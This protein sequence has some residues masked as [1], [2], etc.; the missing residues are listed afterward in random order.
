MAAFSLRRSLLVRLFLLTLA[1]PLLAQQRGIPAS[2]Q[3]G[4]VSVDLSQGRAYLGSLAKPEALEQMRD[5]ALLG[6]YTLSAP[7]GASHRDAL[8]SF[9]PVRFEELASIYFRRAGQTRGVTVSD[10]RFIAMVSEDSKGAQRQLQIGR[11]LDEEASAKGRIPSVVLTFEYRIDDSART[12]AIHA[13][14]QQDGATFFTEAAGYVERRVA[15]G[16]DLEAF[17]KLNADIT[18]ARVEQG[19]FIVGGRRFMNGMPQL[20]SREDLAAIRQAGMRISD[21]VRSHLAR[22]GLQVEYEAEIRK[23]AAEALAKRELTGGVATFA[24]IQRI[25]EQL[26]GARPYERFAAEQLNE[27]M[28]ENPPSIGFSLDPRENRPGIAADLEKAVRGDPALFDGWL[29]HQVTEDVHQAR[30][31]DPDRESSDLS[32]IKA[33]L[34]GAERD[35]TRAEVSVRTLIGLDPAPARTDQPYVDKRDEK[36]SDIAAAQRITKGQRAVADR[37]ADELRRV[38]A[39]L[40][41]NS[42]EA[43]RELLRYLNA[44]AIGLDMRPGASGYRVRDLQQLLRESVDEDLVADGQYGAA[45]TSALRRFQE[46]ADLKPTGIVDTTTWKALLENSEKTAGELAELRELLNSVQDH[47]NYQCARY[48]GRLAGTQVGMTLF[49]TD[50]LMKVWS[51]AGPDHQPSVPGFVSETQYRLSPV[52]WENEK[53]FNST[54]GWLGPRMEAIK[55]R[56]EKVSFAPVATRLYNASSNDLINGK[57]V[58]ATFGPQ[59]FSDWWNAHY[60]DVADYEPQYHRLNQIMKWAVVLLKFEDAAVPALRELAD[61]TV[62]RNLRFDTWWATNK[63]HLRVAPINAFRPVASEPTE[64]MDILHSDLYESMG[65]VYVFSGGVS[66]PRREAI[67]AKALANESRT[68][69]PEILKAPGVDVSGARV[70]NSGIQFRLTEGDMN[71]GAFTLPKGSQAAEFRAPATTLDGVRGSLGASAVRLDYT[72][73]TGTVRVTSSFG[74]EPLFDVSMARLVDALQLNFSEGPFFNALR[75]LTTHEDTAMLGPERVLAIPDTKQLLIRLGTDDRWAIAAHDRLATRG[76]GPVARFGMGQ[77]PAEMRPLS[78]TELASLI[79]PYK[80]EKLTSSTKALNNAFST[81]LVSSVPK[82]T[83]S[84]QIKVGESA[85][86]AFS[87]GDDLYLP[88]ADVPGA[89]ARAVAETLSTDQFRMLVS[90]VDERST[91]TVAAVRGANGDLV[92]LTE[93]NQI[94]AT[95]AETIG[96]ILTSE[97]GTQPLIIDGERRTGVE[98]G[99]HGDIEIA[100]GASAADVA[101]AGRTARLLRGDGS[102]PEALSHLTPLTEADLDA[103][104]NIPAPRRSAYVEFRSAPPLQRGEVLADLRLPATNNLMVRRGLTVEFLPMGGVSSAKLA[105]DLQYVDDVMNP[106]RAERAGRVGADPTIGEFLERTKGIYDYLREVVAQTGAERVVTMESGDVNLSTI[107][108]LHGGDPRVRILRDQSDVHASLRNVRQ[109][110]TVPP[111]T[112]AIGVTAK[113]KE[114]DHLPAVSALVERLQSRAAANLELSF[115]DFRG[116]LEDD[117]I[118]QIALVAREENGGLAFADGWVDASL[119]RM[120]LR[121]GSQKQSI[122]L[123]SNA[124]AELRRLFSDSGRFRRVLSFSYVLGQLESFE[125]ALTSAVALLEAP[126]A[127]TA[128]LKRED[129]DALLAAAGGVANTFKAGVTRTTD[130]TVSIDVNRLLKQAHADATDTDLVLAIQSLLASDVTAERTSDLDEAMSRLPGN[131]IPDRARKARAEISAIPQTKYD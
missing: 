130:D 118:Q 50:L 125:A 57:E 76:A 91:G 16:A 124:G 80:F 47:N 110:V 69:L 55:V 68:D 102:L 129:F 126:G 51:F 85:F 33:L 103:I 59:R 39:S 128:T 43:L 94:S 77:H 106:A 100:R 6:A 21:D 93:G 78:K 66:L 27:L 60:L 67:K 71:R 44:E 95:D 83:T 63:A 109:V 54:R 31:L 73:N 79:A 3:A 19:Q 26:K 104:V 112:S 113:P 7:A 116:L 123:I 37:R 28:D 2:P 92:M 101:L 111:L 20:I 98:I 56:G 29:L 46:S 131:R 99:E 4:W 41:Q 115:S 11:L 82:A 13:L 122:I 18:H 38:T 120:A 108:A 70:D 15:T 97:S 30:H 22:R 17:L 42:S 87:D 75:E 64:C 53:R 5:W 105:A 49:Y 9:L 62:T 12:L 89:R 72:G 40:R 65:G 117:D 81:E 23:Q 58:P 8:I 121:L 35:E 90:T 119:L 61:A 127:L 86:A 84:V 34:G 96:K 107:W 74:T 32:W 10:G 52:Y 88:I 114:A 1:V 25:L 36:L 45:T 14:P 48:D 24:E